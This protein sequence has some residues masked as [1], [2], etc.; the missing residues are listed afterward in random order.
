MKQIQDDLIKV[1]DNNISPFSPA[2]S[3]NSDVDMI[4][5]GIQTDEIKYPKYTRKMIKNM[6]KSGDYVLDNVYHR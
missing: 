2:S 3:E 4:D 6:I 5:G 1:D